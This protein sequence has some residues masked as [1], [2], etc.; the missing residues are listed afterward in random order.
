MY[1]E[2]IFTIIMKV[3]VG[4]PIHFEMRSAGTANLKTG[5]LWVIQDLD[6]ET[7]T[8]FLF[9]VTFTV[10]QTFFFQPQVQVTYFKNMDFNRID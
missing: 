10:G 7:E 9:S 8:F 1:I 6:Y 4:N 2:T 5:Q 3:L